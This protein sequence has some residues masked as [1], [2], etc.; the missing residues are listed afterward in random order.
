MKL[1]I[2]M[3]INDFFAG[4]SS[5]T[6]LTIFTTFA[7]R[8]NESKATR[9]AA[10]QHR[11]KR[12]KESVNKKHSPSLSLPCRI[13]YNISILANYICHFVHSQA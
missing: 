6:H 2:L 11:V 13:N 8:M 7:E 9:E 1:F 12:V 4:N 3:E 5:D 10:C